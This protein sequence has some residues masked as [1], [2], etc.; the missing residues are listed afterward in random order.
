VAEAEAGPMRRRKR[1]QADREARHRREADKYEALMASL[2]GAPDG[3]QLSPLD[4]VMLEQS[5]R[6]AGNEPPAWIVRAC[7]AWLAANGRTRADLGPQR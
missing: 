2:Y 5:I 4:C 6:S 7:T 1:W 3:C